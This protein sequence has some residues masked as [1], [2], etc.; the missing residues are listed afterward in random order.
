MVRSPVPLMK[1]HNP[2]HSVS[3]YNSHYHVQ[4]CST[5]VLLHV[6]STI[7]HCF[8]MSHH[9]RKTILTRLTL[10]QQRRSGQF[11]VNSLSPF[12]YGLAE[13]SPSVLELVKQKLCPLLAI[14]QET[15]IHPFEL[16][17]LEWK[18]T[19]YQS[20]CLQIHSIQYSFATVYAFSL[21]PAVY[22][23]QIRNL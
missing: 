9:F 20:K 7:Q 10:N 8:V 23:C 15:A 3:V 19:A 1:D 2:K 12:P 16:I 18:I 13:T 11:P 6:Q 4:Q 22:R 17:K 5:N 21:S 14:S